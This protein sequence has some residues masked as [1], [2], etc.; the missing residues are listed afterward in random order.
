VSVKADQ[1]NGSEKSLE[2]NELTVPHAMRCA[3][4]FQRK[5]L[6]RNLGNQWKELTRCEDSLLHGLR[7]EMRTLVFTRCI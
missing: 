1:K 5:R 2:R 4:K 3:R 6:G 7:L